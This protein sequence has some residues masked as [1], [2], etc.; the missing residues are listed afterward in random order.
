MRLLCILLPPLA[1]FLS[2]KPIQ[3]L[4]NLPLTLCLW[5]PG[6]IHA[7]IVVSDKREDKRHKEMVAAVKSNKGEAN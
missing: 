6:M 1:V 4:I 2:G 7:W 3:A 5:V